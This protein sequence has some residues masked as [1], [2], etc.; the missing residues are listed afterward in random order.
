MIPAE[1][2][3]LKIIQLLLGVS[4]L[5]FLLTLIL[6]AFVGELGGPI[7]SLLSVACFGALFLSIF[8]LP[9]WIVVW[10]SFKFKENEYQFN[11]RYLFLTMTILAI[12]LGCIGW[13]ISL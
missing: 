4:T 7:A 13:L 12:L 6:D 2:K 3:I 8:L 11:L 5:V 1:H 9:S 10:A